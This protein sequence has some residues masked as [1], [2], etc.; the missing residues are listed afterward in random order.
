[1]S[2]QLIPTG[3]TSGLRTRIAATESGSFCER[4]KS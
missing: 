4:M 2:Q 1:M 3:E